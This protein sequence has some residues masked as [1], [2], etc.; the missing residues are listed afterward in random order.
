MHKTRY[1]KMYLYSTHVQYAAC[2]KEH[3]IVLSDVRY[4]FQKKIRMWIDFG[5]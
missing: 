2:D 4:P 5:D 3:C 1:N